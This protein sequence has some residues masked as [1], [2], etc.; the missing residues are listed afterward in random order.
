MT[1]QGRDINILYKLLQLPCVT[2]NDFTNIG[3]TV[4]IGEDTHSY[5]FT[6]L[7]YCPVKISP[8][9]SPLLKKKLQNG[10]YF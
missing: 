8:T 4:I 7:V 3:N 6:I 5:L 9:F 10:F 2:F 1:M